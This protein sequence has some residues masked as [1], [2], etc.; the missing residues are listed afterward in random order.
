MEGL[1]FKIK[2]YFDTNFII[3]PCG[4]YN[5]TIHNYK[6]HKIGISALIELKINP[7]DYI[8]SGSLDKKYLN[9]I[10]RF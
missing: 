3:H 5:D 8:V 2:I 1:S 6:R 10:R 7:I 9:Y 4:V